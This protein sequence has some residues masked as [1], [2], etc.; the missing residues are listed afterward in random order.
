M[1]EPGART[2]GRLV[3]LD[4]FRAL[5]ILLVILYH[6]AY[7]WSTR[8]PG[9]EGLYESPRWLAG[10]LLV[11]HGYLG[12]QLFFI[13]SGFVIAITL[14]RVGGLLEFAARRVAR[15]VPAM[16]AMS[17]LTFAVLW[18]PAA[19]GLWSHPSWTGFLPSWTFTAPE[20]WQPVFPGAE[21]IDGAYWSLFVEVR[22]YFLAAVVYFGLGR[23]RFERA[24]AALTV[25]AVAGRFLAAALPVSWAERAE[26]VLLIPQHLPLF[27]AGILF[28]QAFQ[29]TA[30]AEG[31]APAAWRGT[32]LLL[33][34]TLLLWFVHALRFPDSTNPVDLTAIVLVGAF[35][36]LFA[37]FVW[38]PAG[39]AIMQGK[40]LARLGVA[41]YSLYL[42][43]Q[44]VGVTLLHALAPSSPAWFP[45]A[46]VLVTLALVAVAFVTWRAVEEPG[47]RW[48][49]RVLL[50]RERVGR[51]GP[52]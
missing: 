36:A 41:S 33:C 43:H 15:L 24:F 13:V 9:G 23:A 30:K 14:R 50:P 28:H 47:R 12:V 20:I 21:Y 34:A 22:F 26:N 35:Y 51:A 27:M 17:L 39:L 3:V 42:V 45:L 49:T 38:R 29:A 52:A 40:A 4:S 11:Q 37:L 1:T 6:F 48:L 7:R 8:F 32:G 19:P 46:V 44:H 16:L 2:A 25:A 31:P 18:T 10:N 5:A